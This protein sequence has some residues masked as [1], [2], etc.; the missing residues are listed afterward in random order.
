MTYYI[1]TCMNLLKKNLWKAH[2]IRI[3][4][5]LVVSDRTEMTSF[6]YLK[7]ASYQRL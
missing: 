2:H 7:M 6:L 3:S 5:I 1:A 4:E